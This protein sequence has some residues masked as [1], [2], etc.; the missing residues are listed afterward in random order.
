MDFVYVCKKQPFAITC[1]PYLPKISENY[2]DMDLVLK[3]NIPMKNLQCT[4]IT[5]AGQ[6][7][8]IVGQISQTVQC[9][10]SGKTKGNAYLKAKVVRDLS[11]LFHADCLA[12]QQLYDKLM[13]PTPSTTTMEVK[14]R[15]HNKNSFKQNMTPG[16]NDSYT[17][18]STVIVNETC[19]DDSS[20]LEDTASNASHDAMLGKFLAEMTDDARAQAVSD[21]PELANHIKQDEDSDNT[22]FEDDLVKFLAMQTEEYRS[23]A[24]E[25][26]PEL[27]PILNTVKSSNTH[28]SPALTDPVL[29]AIA[30]Q[31]IGPTDA[32]VMSLAANTNPSM[33]KPMPVL[34]SRLDN[35]K[36]NVSA[37]SCPSNYSSDLGNFPPKRPDDSLPNLMTKQGYRDQEVAL[38]ELAASHGYHDAVSS[39]DFDQVSMNSE[40]AEYFCR[41]CQLSDQPNII[42]F[43]HDLLDP[44][45]PSKDYD[46]PFEEDEA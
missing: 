25:D 29:A 4:R 24:A 22:S 2:V 17:N 15:G 30:R 27:A 26:Y 45:C 23:Q 46:D 11:K 41:L 9:V 6:N 3:M 1:S 36:S 21:Y 8:R 7:T 43:S 10:V 20:D 5:F 32:Y 19:H 37:L 31:G 33:P 38:Q 16:I 12:G 18:I 35:V 28:S 14:P 39:P 42:T 13:D 34:N 44:E 40:T